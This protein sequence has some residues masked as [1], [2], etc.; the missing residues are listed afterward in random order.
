MRARHERE[1]LYGFALVRFGR[2]AQIFM[3]IEELGELQVELA[4]Y[5]GSRTKDV[6][7][8]YSEIADAEIMIEQLRYMFVSSEIDKIKEKKLDR[9]E[10][11]LTGL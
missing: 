11:L 8:L 7:D 4:K 9:L 10:K 1:N 5:L 3:A 6:Q 2:E